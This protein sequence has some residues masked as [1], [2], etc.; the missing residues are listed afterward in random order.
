MSR[1]GG[2]GRG[3]EALIPGEEAAPHGDEGITSVPV[4]RIDPNPQQPRYWMG[5]AE[6]AELADSIREHGIIQ[7][8]IVTHD[9][10][11][12]RYILIA[13][14]RRL[15]AARLAQLAEVPVII[16]QA[17]DQQ[18]LEIA[19]IE[20]IQ[21]ADLT[22][23]ESADAFQHLNET[24]GLSHEEIARRVGKSRVAITNSLRL[25]KLPQSVKE[26]LAAAQISEGHARALLGLNTAQAQIAALQTVLKLELNVRQTEELVRKLGGTRPE[27]PLR[28]DQSPEIRSLEERLRSHLGTRVSLQRRKKGGIISIHYYSDEELNT[29]I[30]QILKE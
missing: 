26:A 4:D 9:P 20:N 5:D 12:D 6:L 17:T 16:R 7:P 29:L 1:K 23:L 27:R 28:V 13:G 11:H 18:R 22:P 15:R 2:L 10:E 24:F 30:S 3:L 21:R 8:L 25:L 14:E 19:L